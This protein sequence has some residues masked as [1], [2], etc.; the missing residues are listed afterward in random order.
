MHYIANLH[1][2]RMKFINSVVRSVIPVHLFQEPLPTPPTAPFPRHRVP[3]PRAPCGAISHRRRCY[4]WTMKDSLLVHFTLQT[5]RSRSNEI[6][7]NLLIR[8]DLLYIRTYANRS[9]SPILH[10]EFRNFANHSARQHFKQQ[11]RSVNIDRCPANDEIPAIH[12]RIRCAEIAAA[13]HHQRRRRSRGSGEIVERFVVL[14]SK[15][16]LR[17]LSPFITGRGCRWGRVLQVNAIQKTS[18]ALAE[19]EGR[20]ATC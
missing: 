2:T 17:R 4:R 18:T 16:R 1:S 19:E 12:P 5:G 13:H 3:G 15:S 14:K 20:G 10:A 9:R 7:R 8:Y 11:P 6:M